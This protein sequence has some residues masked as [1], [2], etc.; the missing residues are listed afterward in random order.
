MKSYKN[1]RAFIFRDGMWRHVYIYRSYDQETL[2]G[3]PVKMLE[4]RL[5]KNTKISY[6]AEIGSFHK[7]RPKTYKPKSGLS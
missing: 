2:F 1:A 7:T 3:E 5:S 4:Y 6:S